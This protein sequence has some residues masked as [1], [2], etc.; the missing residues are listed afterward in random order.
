MATSVQRKELSSGGAA[1]LFGHVASL[2]AKGKAIG[3]GDEGGNSSRREP[4]PLRPGTQALAICG[5][6]CI[7]AVSYPYFFRAPLRVSV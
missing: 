3:G 2:L 5:A 6:A 4:L 1:G 7:T